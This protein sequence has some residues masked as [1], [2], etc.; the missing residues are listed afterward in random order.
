[1]VDIKL[2][3]DELDYDAALERI[4]ILMDAE[5]DTLE[6]N[7]LGVLATHVEAYEAKHHPIDPP[8]PS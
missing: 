5:I 4:G 1:V 6:G 8:D 3:N 2:I 7:E